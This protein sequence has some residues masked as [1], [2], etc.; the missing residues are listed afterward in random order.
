MKGILCEMPGKNAKGKRDK[1]SYSY[2]TVRPRVTT[3]SMATLKQCHRKEN[4]KEKC[5]K[6][7]NKN[8]KKRIPSACCKLYT[9]A[10]S[11]LLRLFE[12]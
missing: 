4:L 12:Y 6:I 7:Y 5:Y 10:D 3:G 11:Y 2:T 1:N 9:L 8:E